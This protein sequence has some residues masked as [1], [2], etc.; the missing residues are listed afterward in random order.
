MLL[1]V[2]DLILFFGR[3]H[4]LVVHLPIGFLLLAVIIAFL[5]RKEK[6]RALAPSL[7][8]IL[9]LGAVS[10]ALASLLGYMLSWGGDYNPD[11]LF[12]HQ[13]MGIILTVLSFA[14][15]WFRT[16]GWNKSLQFWKANSHFAFLALLILISFT[17]HLGGNLT[18]G[19]EYLL[20]YAPD[21][22]RVMAGMEPKP[23]PRPPVTV[24]D[25]ADIFLDVVHPMIQSKC[26]TCHNQDKMKGELLLTSYQEILEGGEQ[27]PSVV[28]GDLENSLLYQRITLPETHDDY[29]PAE[30]KEGFDEDQI[31]LIQWWIENNAPP[32]MLLAGMKMESNMASKFE[33]VL[34]ISTSETRLPEKEIA[35]ADSLAVQLVR[36][37]GF[38]IK[39]II[40]ESNFLEVRLPYNGQNLQDMDIKALLDLK[41]HIAWMDFSK[42]EVEDEDLETIGQIKSLSRL[43]LSNNSV[44]D[45]GIG[46][47][48]DLEELRY[49]NLYGTSVSDQGLNT[50]KSL[51]KLRSLYLWQTQVSDAGVESLKAERPD[52]TVTLGFTELKIAEES[53]SIEQKVDG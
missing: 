17:G 2:P 16:R 3:F 22:L 8:F 51:K 5:S 21:P 45:R 53:D 40:P 29:M 19:S 46:L 35:A 32:T 4:P 34:G 50:L 23:V 27:G 10:A 36:E 33:R 20:Q 15:Y 1:D 48:K 37:E 49:L 30:G 47:L 6:F 39:K 7:D 9:L 12:W 14:I 24:L 13:W 25:S 42:G 26:Q 11:S 18:H 31:A 43:N 41:D 52:I 44:T 38:I 28:P